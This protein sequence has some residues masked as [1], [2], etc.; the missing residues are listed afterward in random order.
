MVFIGQGRF[1]RAAPPLVQIGH[2]R[3]H[4][5]VVMHLHTGKHFLKIPSLGFKHRFPLPIFPEINIQIIHKMDGTQHKI[6]TP[7]G[8]IPLHLLRVIRV[9]AILH[10]SA[11]FQR[12]TGKAI[13]FPAVVFF[14][15]NHG[16]LCRTA[17]IIHMVGE[18]D[19]PQARLFRCLHQRRTGVVAIEGNPGMYMVV[20]HNLSP[21][22]IGGTPWAA[23]PFLLFLPL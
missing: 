9:Q 3:Q 18:A 12:L 21:P 4:V 5:I 7:P 23:P 16:L 8:A 17:H 20:K 14:G 11:D 2:V 22:K 19:L 15:K 1:H 6:I 10:P 13:I